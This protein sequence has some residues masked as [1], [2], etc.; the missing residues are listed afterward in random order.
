MIDLSLLPHTV[1]AL[2][3]GDPALQALAPRWDATEAGAHVFV[4]EPPPGAAN[5]GRAPYVVLALDEGRD[6][7]RREGD[8]GPRTLTAA[9]RLRLVARRDASAIAW[10]IR[11]VL[12]DDAHRRLGDPARVLGTAVEM[13]AIE[14]LGP[15]EAITLRFHVRLLD[16]GA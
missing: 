8:A 5:V 7:A 2:L 14:P 10:R 1:A 16:A 13:G 11:Q 12:A 4:G 3:R 15:C 9:V 6:P